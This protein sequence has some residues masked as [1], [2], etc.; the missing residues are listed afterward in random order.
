METLFSILSMALSLVAIG[1]GYYSFRRTYKT[2]IQPMLVFMN[3]GK[4]DS[5]KSYWYVENVGNG[6]ALNVLVTGGNT[7]LE[8]SKEEAVLLSAIARGD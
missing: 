2:S 8:W 1:F 6:P 4:D 3:D 5:G 7:K